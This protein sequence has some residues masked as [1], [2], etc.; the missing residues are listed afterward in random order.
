MA[1]AGANVAIA[2][3]N[4]EGAEAVAAEASALSGTAKA[5][6]VDIT[7]RNQV[8]QMVDAV[9][10]TWGRIDVLVNNVGWDKIGPFIETTPEFWTQSLEINFKG[11]LHCTQAVLKYMIEQ[12][13]GA[14]V[15]VSSD[16]GR[17][18]SSWQAVYSGAKGAVLAFTKAVAREVVRYGIRVNCVCPGLTDTPMLAA[19]REANP[20]LVD[21]IV[22]AIPMRRVGRPEEIAQ[23]IAFLASDRASYITGQ[24]LSVN[25]GLNMV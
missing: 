17:V 11:M 9:H 16:A 15:N 19:V 12:Q 5:F 8:D 24:A 4:L 18:G 2:D 1:E 23:A 25:G 6:Q 22:K 7:D 10:R 3:L 13:S 14:I 21:A 20:K